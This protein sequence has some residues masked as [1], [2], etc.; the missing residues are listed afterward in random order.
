MRVKRICLFLLYLLAFLYFLWSEEV[1]KPSSK[2]KY[3]K[4]SVRFSFQGEALFAGKA[5]KGSHPPSYREV[6][7]PGLGGGLEIG[8]SFHP[9]HQAFLGIEDKYYNG[10]VFEGVKFSN[11]KITLVYA[12][13]KM[14]LLTNQEASLKPYLKVEIGTASLN[15]IEIIYH[16]IHNDYWDSSRVP[17]VRAGVGI[18]LILFEW[19]PYSNGVF[20]EIKGQYLG[21]PPSLMSP[22]SDSRGCWSLPI[23]VGLSFNL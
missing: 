13:W 16:E 21:K 22:H 11:R 18:E 4:F 1:P 14:N 7:R 23:S 20:L 8:F 2:E 15:K 6:F 10:Q 17:M 12:G 9:K 3:R 5:G 19:K